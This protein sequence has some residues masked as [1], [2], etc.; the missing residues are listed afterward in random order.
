MF[1]RLCETNPVM[2]VYLSLRFTNTILL[3]FWTKLCHLLMDHCTV[4][5]QVS[6][7]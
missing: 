4:Q 6:F 3:V 2:F 7:N 1:V 5:E